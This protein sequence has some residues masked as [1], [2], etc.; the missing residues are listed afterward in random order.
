MT[1]QIIR[2]METT[3]GSRPHRRDSWTVSEDSPVA[4]FLGYELLLTEDVVGQ[5]GLLA[6]H[7]LLLDGPLAPRRH[8]LRVGDHVAAVIQQEAGHL[9]GLTPAAQ[10]RYQQLWNG[11]RE[12]VRAAAAA[13]SQ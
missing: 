7:V 10:H 2:R 11:R 9:R 5:Q 12:S 6:G 3:A 4:L 1:E 8:V 13:E